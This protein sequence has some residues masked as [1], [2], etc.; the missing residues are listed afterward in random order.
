MRG[1]R[2]WDLALERAYNQARVYIRNLPATEGRPPFLIVCDVDYVIEL[3]SEFTC[4]GGTYLRFPDP[5]S[6][7]IHLE[8]LRDAAIRDRLRAVWTDP[9]SLDPS[10]RVTRDVAEHL[11]R[12]AKSLDAEATTHRP[13][14]PSCNAAASPSLP[15]TPACCPMAPSRTCSSN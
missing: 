13:L 15:K 3:Y 6:H 2:S 11:S 10:T 5:K 8:D 1:T 14:P 4:T 9:A 12:L 7:R